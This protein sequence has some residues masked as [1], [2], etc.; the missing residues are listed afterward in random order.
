MS[1]PPPPPNQP[2]AGGPGAPQ[3]P[4]SGGFGAPQSP[5]SGGFGA[6]QDPPSGGFGAP[7]DPPSGG[8]GAPQDPPSGGFGAPQDPPSGGF[9]APQS[10]PSGGFGAP[11]DPPPGGF[12]APQ[13]PPPGGFGAPQT[14]PP[15]SQTPPQTPP[16]PAQGPGY[17]YPQPQTMP[18]QPYGHPQTPPSYGYPNQQPGYGYAQPSA[19][20]V[21]PQAAKGAG[22]KGPGAQVWIIVAAVAAIALIVGAGVWYSQSSSGGDSGKDPVA[23]TS[24]GSGSG[25]GGEDKG[26]T[27]GTG[28][29]AKE[30]PEKVPANTSAKVLFQLP[31]PDIKDKNEIDSV[32]GSWLTDSVY[33]KADLYKI[34]GY[35]PDTGAVKWTM[36]LNGQTCAGSTEITTS[37]IAV[38]VSESGKRSGAHDRKPCSDVTAF[39]VATGKKLWTK[40]VKTGDS[41]VPFGEV[42]ISGNTV[43]AGGGY[44]GGAAFDLTTGKVLWQPKTGSCTDVGY[45]GGEQLVAVRK[46]GDYGSEIYEVQL[47]D[48]KTG[49]DKWSYKLPQG[50]DNAKV[51]ST[52]PVVFGLDAGDTSLTGTTDVFSLDDSGKLRAKITL[53]DGR[54]AHDCK[55]G[56][57]HDCHGIVV[58]NDKLYVPTK[59]HDGAGKY[60]QTN[61][62]I[63][64][65][66]ATGKTTGDKADAGDE[67][68]LFPMRMNGGN[69]LAYKDG[70]YDKGAQVV[71]IDGKTLK[72]TLLLETPGSESVHRAISSMVPKSSELLYTDGRLFFGQQL[73]S[74]PYSAKDKSYT[75][76]GFGAK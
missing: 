22:R 56:K 68:E 62:I 38:V 14:P 25:G 39:E 13:S 15:P 3:D 76:L 26:G 16:P 34:V 69:I 7:Q 67:Y 52:K 64:F 59:E 72:T 58:G 60:S 37:G 24:G 23:G 18:Q 1:Q 4:P 75:A 28:G 46:C 12:G 8:F 74:K 45:A 33:A 51:I 49:K 65:S 54:Y 9:G 53:E 10:P 63:S 43:A 73:V 41:P 31:A 32:A 71:S 42:A 5:P 47:L 2:P 48:S 19:V 27:G 57:V 30:K 35:E 55:I 40:S 36:P 29:V 11:Q 61:E 17:G 66:L 20:P 21:Q 70:P 6:P 50:I 44:Y